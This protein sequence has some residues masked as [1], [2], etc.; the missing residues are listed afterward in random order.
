MI[1]YTY[2]ATISTILIRFRSYNLLP[3]ISSVLCQPLDDPWFIDVYEF[4]S[5]QQSEQIVFTLDDYAGCNNTLFKIKPHRYD[6]EL[7]F[8]KNKFDI[9]ERYKLSRKLYAKLLRKK[10]KIALWAQTT[11][12]KK[13]KHRFLNEVKDWDLACPKPSFDQWFDSCFKQPSIRQQLRLLAMDRNFFSLN[14]SITPA[15]LLNQSCFLI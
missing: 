4:L 12:L 9:F 7:P 6:R 13:L 15:R 5:R 1:K 14:S 8:E 3:H 10:M 2:S 11:T